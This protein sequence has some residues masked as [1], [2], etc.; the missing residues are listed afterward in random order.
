MPLPVLSR[1]SFAAKATARQRLLPVNSIV[2]KQCISEK[3]PGTSVLDSCPYSTMQNLPRLPVPPLWQTLQKFLIT[4]KPLLPLEKY[5][6]ATELVNKFIHP[7]GVGEKLQHLLEERAKNTV[8]WLEEWWLNIAYLEYR[9]PVPIHV[10]PGILMPTLSFRGS[11]EQLRYAARLIAYVIE[12]KKMIDE[13]TLPID[14]LGKSDLC[15]KQFYRILGCCRIPG[16]KRDGVLIHPGGKPDSPRHITVIRNG[17]IYSLDVYETNGRPLSA[18]QLY[19]QLQKIANLSSESTL[20]VG[21]LTSEHRDNWYKAYAHLV[22][23]ETNRKSLES[24]HQSIFVLCLDKS[25]VEVNQKASRETVLLNQVDHGGGSKQNSGNR[26]FDKIFQVIVSPDGLIGFNYEHSA[27]EGPPILHLI[28]YCYPRLKEAV[29]ISSSVVEKDPKKLQFNIDG[30]TKQ[31]IISASKSFDN[32]I[33]DLELIYYEFP[34]FGKETLKRLQ[35]S[36]DAFI[37]VAFQLAYYRIY[38]KPAPTYE[39]GSLR[40]FQHGRTD[41]IR[42]C[43]SASLAYC[44]AMTSPKIPPR[45]QAN[46]L[47]S[48]LASHRSYTDQVINGEGIDRHLLGLKFIALENKIEVPELLRDEVHETTTYWKI[49]T[50]QVPSKHGGLLCF[51]PVVPEGYGICYNPMDDRLLFAISTWRSCAETDAGKFSSVLGQSLEDGK[52]LLELGPTS[53]L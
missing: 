10:N 8:N 25:S 49:S 46:L 42:S 3:Q 40:K 1:L 32:L 28:D 6:H 24:I 16:D 29:S 14:R 7:G 12:Y 9:L 50:S 20:P 11:D 39:S 36:P 51:G 18:G 30:D 45:D 38:G 43:S 21:I 22:K 44:Q 52:R 26:W 2:L 23:D 41:T 5:K 17:H 27:A 53:K 34:H 4:V 35:S 47:R 48:A 15:M 19:Q 33:N 37:Q 13:A 31:A